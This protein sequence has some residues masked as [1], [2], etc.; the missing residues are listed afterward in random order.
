MITKQ[1][2]EFYHSTSKDNFHRILQDGRLRSLSSIR[3]GGP[4][5]VEAQR[6]N[7]VRQE[8]TPEE[9]VAAQLAEGKFPDRVFLARGGIVPGYGDYHI[10]KQLSSPQRSNI[11]N[12][13]PGEHT[14]RRALSVRSNADFIVPDEELS[15]F[16]E[17]YPRLRSRFRTNTDCPVRELSKAQALMELPGKLVGSLREKLGAEISPR[18]INRRA[19][20]GGSTGIGIGIEGV[21]DYDFMVPYSTREQV[22]RAKG[23]YLTKYPGLHESPFNEGRL[24]KQVLTGD[25]DGVDVD[26]VLAQGEGPQRYIDSVKAARARLTPEEKA[27]IIARKAALKNALFFPETRY[28]RYKKQ[29]DRDLSIQPF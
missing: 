13:V 22:L 11:I 17:R 21:K 14:T 8:L 18:D 16:R 19:F 29:L 6:W 3:D 24:N 25:I 26:V 23:R 15:E 4:L 10:R 12:L 2:E 27:D 5:S 20:L 28:K 9:A 1:A 7:R